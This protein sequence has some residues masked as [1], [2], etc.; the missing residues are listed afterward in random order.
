[1]QDPEAALMALRLAKS[2]GATDAVSIVRTTDWRMIRFSNNGVT[3]SKVTRETS[4]SIFMAIEGRKSS[5]TTTD[6]SRRSVD[7]LVRN[8]MNMAKISPPSE[9][10][11]PLPVGPFKYRRE[12][13]SVGD[14]RLMSEKLPDAVKAA[15]EAAISEGAQR[16]AG[17][18]IAERTS[19]VIRTTGGAKGTYASTSYDLSVR[20]FADPEATGQFAQVATRFRD[21]DPENVGR[22]AGEIAKKAMNPK[23]AEPGRYDAVLGPMTVADLMEEVALAASAYGV[24][25]GLSF[26]TDSLGKKVASALFSIND[27]PTDERAPG[28]AP[29]D[30]EGLPTF[31]KP[32]IEDGILK[33]YL[34]N[35]LTAKMMGAKSTANAGLVR[36]VAFNLKIRAGDKS[37]EDLV[38]MVDNGIYI[39]NNWYLRY[40]NTRNG[41]F[42]TILRDGLF[43]VEDGEIAGPIRGLRLSDNMLRLLGN[44]GAVGAE[45]HWIKWWEVDIPTLTPAML[46]NR[47]NFT[48]PTL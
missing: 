36:P 39:T 41:D 1:M 24:E 25:A 48:S 31:A 13:M 16:V 20:A 23:P 47:V 14:A 28:S 27:D 12:L 3:A 33:T 46:I 34:H 17:S 30:E 26:L 43:K 6:L 7:D 22:Q 21:L 40:Q 37:V 10:Y 32:I 38:S 35:S 15:I 9:V 29:F 44:I 5:F 11:A 4:L 2:G 18:L 45:R 19:K 8:A 42:S